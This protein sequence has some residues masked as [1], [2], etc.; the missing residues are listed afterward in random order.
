MRL[1]NQI[2]RGPLQERLTRGLGIQERSPAPTLAADVQPV[3]LL[4]DLTRQSPFAQP[5]NR[6]ATF[7]FT[8]AAVAGEAGIFTISAPPPP[9][10]AIYV[11]RRIMAS[12]SLASIIQWGFGES[13][14]ATAIV[15][16]YYDARNGDRPGA[17]CRCGTDAVI[18]IDRPLGQRRVST[19]LQ[20]VEIDNLAIV[21]L[22]RNAFAPSDVFTVA[23]TVVNS[24]LMV[25]I[26]F[27]EYIGE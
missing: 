3:V 21:I 4:E 5:S 18:P 24:E 1:F 2:Q 8:Q 12:A 10:T 16:R 25:T 14:E 26:E 27:D 13:D 17:V 6:R 19:T 9:S 7:N 20:A 15:P 11:V 22:P 23:N